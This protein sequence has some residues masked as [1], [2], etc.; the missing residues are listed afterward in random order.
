MLAFAIAL[1]FMLA[2][3]PAS[4]QSCTAEIERL[5]RQ[6][7]L[8]PGTPRSGSTEAPA[9]PAGHEPGAPTSER[10]G[11]TGGVVTPPDIDAPMSVRP[12]AGNPDNMPTAPPVQEP[13]PGQAALTDAER[14]RMAALLDEARAAA[15]QG[16]DAQCLEDLR[17]AEAV[18]GVP[19]SRRGQ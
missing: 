8:G 14:A 13:P 11:R 3:A 9:P 15:R 5:A 2:D 19:G 17:A 12:P 7:D 4:A 10:L 1:P 6:Y 16:K 18:P